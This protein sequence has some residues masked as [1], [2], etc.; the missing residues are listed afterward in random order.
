MF[1]LGVTILILYHKNL[2]KRLKVQEAKDYSSEIANDTWVVSLLS[3][4]SSVPDQV[5][6]DKITSRSFTARDGWQRVTD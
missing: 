1:V 4:L 5:R 3:K 6:N 2:P